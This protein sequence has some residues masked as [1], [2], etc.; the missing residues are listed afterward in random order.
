MANGT[1]SFGQ[2]KPNNCKCYLLTIPNFNFRSTSYAWLVV[3]PAGTNAQLKGSGTINGVGSYQFMLWARD[4]TPD[5][6]R[7]K[8]WSEGAAGME[9]V[10]YDNRFDQAIDGGS[11][12]VHK[13]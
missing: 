3:N 13:Q 4:G 5:T 7:V 1:T 9:T 8:I 2:A 11:I 6:F 10:V 12:V